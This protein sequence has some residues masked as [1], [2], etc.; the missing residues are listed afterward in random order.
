VGF[1]AVVHEGLLEPRV[2]ESF[3][4]G[5]ALLRVVHEDPLQQ[6]KEL[7]VELGV[8]W[9]AFLQIIS[10]KLCVCAGLTYVELLHSLY[11]LLRALMRVRVGIF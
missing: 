2:L 6:V 10:T 9:Y 8:R 7:P 3:F 1:G 5:D 4:G 11:K